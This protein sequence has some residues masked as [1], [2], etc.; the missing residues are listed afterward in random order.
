VHEKCFDSQRQTKKKVRDGK[1]NHISSRVFRTHSLTFLLNAG[2]S[3][4]HIIDAS[5]FAAESQLGSLSIERTDRR[6]VS[7]IIDRQI[8]I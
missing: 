6:I 8:L 3:S 2:L 1:F 4:R 5:M 7:K